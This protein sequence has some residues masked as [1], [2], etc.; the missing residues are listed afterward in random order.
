MVT[1]FEIL[2]PVL[3]PKSYQATSPPDAAYNC[4][5][6]A[7]GETQ[8]WWW[9]DADGLAYWPAAAAR[10]ETVAAFVTAFGALGYSPCSGDQVE[11]GFEKVALFAD[12]QGRPRHAARQLP[13]GRWTSKM[14]ELEDI[15]HGLH[16]LAGSVYGIVVQVLRRPMAVAQG[17]Q[18]G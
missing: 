13:S 6:W 5:A 12:A 18:P 1:P 17:N 10:D 7:A 3:Q 8:T 11:P 14:G 15:E 9:P 16:D 4:I 2:F